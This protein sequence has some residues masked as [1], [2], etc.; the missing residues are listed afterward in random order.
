[1]RCD[2]GPPDGHAQT[3]ASPRQHAPRCLR[4][5]HPPKHPGP[6]CCGRCPS[7]APISLPR[8]PAAPP[9]LPPVL[10]APFASPNADIDMPLPP[11]LPTALPPFSSF[12][13]KRAP[14]KY[15][16]AVP[17]S[18][19]RQ[20]PAAARPP[21]GALPPPPL[22]PPAPAAC[23][24]RHCPRAPHPPPAPLLPAAS[25]SCSYAPAHFLPRRALA[26]ASPMHVHP[27]APALHHFEHLTAIPERL[28]FLSMRPSV[29]APRPPPSPGHLQL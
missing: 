13:S 16:C 24:C 8:A 1:M 7:V 20:R 14:P 27:L 11:L 3:P 6:H 12:S 10:L 29:P 17:L 9:P 2:G 21:T 23:S 5:H 28:S 18:C 15:S 25:P 4:R 19:A 22:C 26:H